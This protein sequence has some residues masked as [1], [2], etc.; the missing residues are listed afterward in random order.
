MA[1]R[2]RVPLIGCGSHR[3]NLA[4]KEV[5]E[6]IKPILKKVHELM[7][8]LSA[9][10][11]SAKLRRTT[12]LEPIKRNVTRWSSTFN[13]LKRFFELVEY[14]DVRDTE[15]IPFVPSRREEEDLRK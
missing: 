5:L 2:C 7:G 4:V 15:L 3:L 11:Q 12:N 13:M 10:K 6:P 8:K 1:S 9:I 14:L